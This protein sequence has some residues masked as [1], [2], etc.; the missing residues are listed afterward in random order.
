MSLYTA[1]LLA[2]LTRRQDYRQSR[3]NWLPAW[4]YDD[5]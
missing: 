1:S 2:P 5:K 4:L 3:L